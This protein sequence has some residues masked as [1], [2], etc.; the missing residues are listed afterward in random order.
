MLFWQP[1][2]R[3]LPFMLGISSYFLF[4][5]S[6]SQQ[7]YILCTKVAR[8]VC[9]GN[10]LFEKVGCITYQI[11]KV[12]YVTWHNRFRGWR[13]SWKVLSVYRH[14]NRKKPNIF[15]TSSVSAS[16][17]NPGFPLP[18]DTCTKAQALMY[19]CLDS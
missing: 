1:N 12:L 15:L 13:Y 7:P 6:S 4:A 19:S 18:K 8:F 16:E 11:C 2:P 3:I 17:E 5:A 10:P 9:P 14:F